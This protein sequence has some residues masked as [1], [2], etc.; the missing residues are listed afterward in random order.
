M[1]I[2]ENLLLAMVV[3]F[4]LP[5]AVWRA[6]GGTVVLPLVVVQIIAGVVLGPGVLG[7]WAPD[8]YQ[9][10]FRVEV[11]AGINAVAQWAVILFVFVAG[12]ELDMTGIW[13]ERRETTLAAGFALVVP[14]VL[15]TLVAW[16][17]VQS[18]GWVGEK[19]QVWQ[20]VL[21][22][23]MACAVTALPILVLF[24]RQLGLL[25]QPLRHRPDWRSAR[26]AGFAPRGHAVRLSSDLRGGRFWNAPAGTTFA[27]GRPLVCRADLA[28]GQ[29]LCGRLGGAAL[30]G[31]RFPVGRCA[32]GAVV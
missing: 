30:Y 26:Y 4:A 23:G 17:L 28:S 12:L 29:C 6:L 10:L 25:R 3:I 1:S 9:G 8:I 5:W 24:L 13:K 21:G 20:A 31:R 19:G 16:G 18:P 7:V 27:R 2:S 32:R 11:I 15:G 14:L 22:I